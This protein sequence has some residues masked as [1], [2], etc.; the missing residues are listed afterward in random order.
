MKKR[1]EPQQLAAELAAERLAEVERLSRDVRRALEDMRDLARNT[2]DMK[3]KVLADKLD[4]V[5]AAHLRVL[6]AEDAFREKIGT[7][8]DAEAID[9]DA[10]RAD[11]GRQLD[12]LRESLAAEGIPREADGGST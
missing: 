10:I 6:R 4:Q 8:S 5:H 12:R 1:D 2:P 9:H 3:P 11:I 7:D